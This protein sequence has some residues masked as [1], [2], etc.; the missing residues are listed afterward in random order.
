MNSSEVENAVGDDMDRTS[1]P[2]VFFGDWAKKSRRA[3]D[4]RG[5]GGLLLSLQGQTKI[6][7]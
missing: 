4:R 6:K 5:C 2:K 7:Q 1:P 3:G